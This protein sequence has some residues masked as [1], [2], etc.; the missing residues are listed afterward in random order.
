MTPTERAIKLVVR[1]RWITA[2]A[3]ALIIFLILKGA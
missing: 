1:L 2:A 3:A